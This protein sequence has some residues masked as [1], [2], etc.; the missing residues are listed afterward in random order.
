MLPIILLN[1]NRQFE[2]TRNLVYRL[3]Y[4]QI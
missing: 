2:R 4:S 1:G 3:C